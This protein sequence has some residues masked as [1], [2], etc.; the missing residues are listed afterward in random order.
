MTDQ[1]VEFKP[2]GYFN[3]SNIEY[4]LKFVMLSETVLESTVECD[5]LI[6][7]CCGISIPPE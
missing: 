4:V 7:F 5:A 1:K 3:F 2:Q 6:R